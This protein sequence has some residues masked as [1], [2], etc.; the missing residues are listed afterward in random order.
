MYTYKSRTE[1]RFPIMRNAWKSII[2][3]L[4]TKINYKRKLMLDSNKKIKTKAEDEAKEG[5][6]INLKD[7]KN[8]DG[9]VRVKMLRN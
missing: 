7:Y 5:R 9:N 3:A 8:K 6:I 1:P 2:S 4:K